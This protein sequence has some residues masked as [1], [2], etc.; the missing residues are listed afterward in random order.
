MPHE[1]GSKHTVAQGPC[2][3][4]AAQAFAAGDAAPTRPMLSFHDRGF[5]KPVYFTYPY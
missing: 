1:A 4:D 2:S 5:E 3:V